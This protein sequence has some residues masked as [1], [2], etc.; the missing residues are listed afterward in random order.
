MT[1]LCYNQIELTSY[2]M[3]KP[4]LPPVLV[5]ETLA[6]IFHREYRGGRHSY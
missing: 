4:K 1:S 2:I 3:E 6:D 5:H